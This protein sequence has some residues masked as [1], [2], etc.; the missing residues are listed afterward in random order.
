[1]LVVLVGLVTV[2]LVPVSGTGTGSSVWATEFGP[3]QSAASDSNVA[4]VSFHGS[5]IYEE[6]RGDIVTIPIEILNSQAGTQV[7]VSVGT[8]SDS[9]Y[10][11]DVTVADEDG[12][13]EVQV[14]F[15]TYTAGTSDDGHTVATASGVDSVERVDERGGFPDQVSD[16]TDDTIAAAS[17][18][19][20]VWRGATTNGNDNDTGTVDLGTRASYSLIPWQAPR[21][22]TF[23][24]HSDFKEEVLDGTVRQAREIPRGNVL[25]LQATSS[26]IAGA[27]ESEL[28]RGAPNVTAA[29]LNL[30]GSSD[31][32]ALGLD[33]AG[34]GTTEPLDSSRLQFLADRTN[35]TYYVVYPTEGVS[36]IEVG[37]TYESTFT[38]RHP[39]SASGGGSVAAEW[40]VTEPVTTPP[41]TPTS[42]PPPTSTSTPLPTPTSTPFPER[43]PS[44]PLPGG[45]G[46]NGS[47][48]SGA[49]PG[50]ESGTDGDSGL[51]VVFGGLGVVVL[52]VTVLGGGVVWSRYAG[53]DD[54]DTTAEG[55]GSGDPDEG[56]EA[57]ERTDP[58]PDPNVADPDLGGANAHGPGPAAGSSGESDGPP[59]ALPTA[60]PVAG[61]LSHDR[62]RDRE[63]VGQG[64]NADVYRALVDTPQGDRPVAVKEPRVKG[65]LHS[66]QIERLMTES[67]TW[68]KLD[69]HDHVVTVLDWGTAPLP[70]IAME[71]MDGGHLGERAGGMEFDQ[72]LWTAIAVTEAV[73]HAHRRGVAHLDLKPENV[74]FREVEDGWDVPKVGDWGLSKQLL[75]HSKS[76][77]G[78]SPQYSAPEQ[79]DDEL[80]ATDDVTD[81]YQLGAVLYELF[82][83]RPPFEGESA[84]VMRAVLDEEPAPPSDVADVPPELDDVLLPALAKEKRDRYE[85]VLYVR[86]GLQDLQRR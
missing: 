36:G 73:R 30:V 28:D 62:F 32:D 8:V 19:L 31:G 27:I 35:D 80:G 57:G 33:I 72:A 21:G 25:I 63:L 29:F 37:T 54:P 79:F 71:Y 68:D 82:T 44:G 6:S 78:L 42:T 11:A 40:S 66:D 58:G 50:P 34:G 53:D 45:D 74:L 15:N 75:D 59:A 49:G 14:R 56:P 85:S 26:G 81:V 5:G 46:G 1:V 3:A 18:S 41:S 60:P 48:E 4:T 47:D 70:W 10:A 39:S 12:D 22:T 24:S 55:S 51:L 23:D 84:T 20:R 2:G 65:T 77:E 16:P 64:G 86:D 7:T 83:G 67:E 61:S 69:D 76:V 43:S 13:G 52:G 38:V 17:Y 9:D